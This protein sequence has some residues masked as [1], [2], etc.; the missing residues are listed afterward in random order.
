MF[1]FC[2][3]IV[4][5]DQYQLLYLPLIHIQV[6]L[7]TCELPNRS[8]IIYQ[9]LQDTYLRQYDVVILLTTQSELGHMLLH[10]TCESDKQQTLFPLDFAI[11]Q[12]RNRWWSLNSLGD[13]TYSFANIVFFFFNKLYVFFILHLYD[14]YTI[15][16][17]MCCI[18]GGKCILLKKY[19]ECFLIV[20]S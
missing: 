12:Y 7:K 11:L 8:C 13:F 9:E 15:S 18:R 6:I 14:Q 17:L 20:F 1:L 2:S 4:S 5:F 3:I 10:L 19:S 16:L